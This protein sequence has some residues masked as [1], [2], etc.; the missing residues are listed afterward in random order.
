[1]RRGPELDAIFAAND[2][3]AVGAITVLRE[4]GRRVPEDVMVAGFDDSVFATQSDP[5]LTTMQQPFARIG[6]EMV[7]L[8]LNAI[9]GEESAYL[10]LSTRLVKRASTA[11]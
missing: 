11:A 8:L 3:M 9:E 7:R 1:V 5:E 10:I 2:A 4:S 6:N